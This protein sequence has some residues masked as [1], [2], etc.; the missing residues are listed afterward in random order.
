[1]I[2]VRGC[3][4]GSWAA[5]G[6][7]FYAIHLGDVYLQRGANFTSRCKNVATFLHLHYMLELFF[8]NIILTTIILRV[9]L[10]LSQSDDII[11]F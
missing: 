1:M 8:S 11:K 7:R 3:Q 4:S 5:A 10:F 2:G 6:D 9:R